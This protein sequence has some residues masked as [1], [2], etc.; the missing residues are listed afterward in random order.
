[1]NHAITFHYRPPRCTFWSQL[2]SLFNIRRFVAFD[3]D[4]GGTTQAG[5]PGVQGSTLQL[6]AWE[7]SPSVQGATGPSPSEQ[8]ASVIP[9]AR[10]RS[11]RE[12]VGECPLADNAKDVLSC[13]CPRKEDPKWTS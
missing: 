8:G 1:M 2:Q 6:L 5:Q 10:A 9:R 7:L 4:R 3:G 11:V 13:G 12:N